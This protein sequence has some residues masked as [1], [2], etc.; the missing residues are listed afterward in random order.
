MEEGKQT[1][2]MSMDCGVVTV[3]KTGV[4]S[5]RLPIGAGTTLDVCHSP[6]ASCDA[7]RR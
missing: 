7:P 3:G 6:V 4:F 5:S 2:E 1:S